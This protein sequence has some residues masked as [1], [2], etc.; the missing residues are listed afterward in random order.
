MAVIQLNNSCV[1]QG[2]GRRMLWKLLKNKKY[3]QAE[4]RIKILFLR[5]IK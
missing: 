4:I 3:F 1:K 2:K 5:F